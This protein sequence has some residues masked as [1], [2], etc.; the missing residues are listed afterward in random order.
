MQL[1]SSARLLIGALPAGGNT[2]G[3]VN[4]A[5]SPW[6]VNVSSALPAGSNVIGGVTQSG[7]PWTTSDAADGSVSGGSAGTKSILSGGQYN[8]SLPSLTT[9]QQA[10]LQSDS[11]GRLLVGSIASALPAGSNSIGSVTANAGT[12]NFN[13]VQSSG[14][15]L[16][17]N[18]DSLPSIP[19]GSN[20]IGGVTQSGGPW[21]TSDAADGSVTGGSAG[22]KS[23]LSGAQYNASPI[24]L[25]TG[26][27]A[28]LQSDVNG[29][30]LIGALAP[31]ANA[32]GSV[33][34]NSALPAGA[35]SIGSVTANIGTTN[36]LALNSTLLN[37]QGSESGGTAATS[38]QLGGVVYNTSLPSLTNGQQAAMQSDSS[39][40]LLVGSIASNV[41]VGNVSG[42]V[43]LP[44]NAAQETGGNLASINT[45]TTGLNA[46]IQN[47]QGSASGGTAASKSDLA[48][49]VYNGGTLPSL[50]AGQQGGLQLDS[51]GRIIF[52][53]GL[54]TSGTITT[55]C[56]T[57]ST[58]C[59]AGSFVMVPNNGF[60]SAQVQVTG[61]F[62]GATFNVDGTADGV[63]WVTL[64][65]ASGSNGQ[66]TTNS[67]S[68]VGKYRVFRIASLQQIRLRASALGSGSASVAFESGNPTD[69]VEAISL[70]AANN[71]TTSYLDDGSG[72]ALTST[73]VSGHQAL[74]SNVVQSV[75]PQDKSISG[76]LT[77]ACAS[78]TSCGAGSTLTLSV[79]G[80]SSSK[81][82]LSGTW[83]GT[84]VLDCS[85]DSFSTF[86]TLSFAVP[87]GGAPVSSLSS[88]GYWGV[89]DPGSC[90][91]LRARMSAFSSGSAT[92]VLTASEGDGLQH[93]VSLNAAELLGTMNVND[94]SGNPIGSTSLS[95]VNYLDAAVTGTVASGS[96]DANNPVK[97]GGIYES[98][99]TAVST[100]QRSN[101][102]TTSLGD[103]T[104]GDNTKYT[105]ISTATTT[106]VKSGAGLLYAICWNKAVNAA[107]DTIY[108]N[109]AASGTEIGIVT[110]V[111]GGGAGFP[112]GCTRY[113]GM[114][115]NTGLTIVTSAASDLTV[116]YK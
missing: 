4:Q 69:L 17:A 18:I 49:G 20:V 101:A 3:A 40:R 19:S 112:F 39:G 114:Q 1:D 90:N 106:T 87:T 116:L 91:Q 64:L 76:S 97:I 15:N 78:G 8:S 107:T 34:I 71:L 54:S 62:S 75:T 42:T 86:K 79:S 67:F 21:T 45:N 7:G 43:S 102:H 26:Q 29:K 72:N 23:I 48:G 95:S 57:P 58:A 6:G 98:S 5:G 36:G 32:I 66:Y 85:N 104:T 115:F 24:T 60:G 53:A 46:S 9:G 22:S 81:L 2:I 55:T 93:V 56:S 12:G 50:T 63:N 10:A 108:D 84:V 100:G 16:H 61:T 65:T 82:N 83:S 47:T 25:T 35:N 88:N 68:A 99:Q 103:L 92:T 94:G 89:I 73:A 80:I 11:S 110:E 109:T 96:A 105:H 30:L 70:N 14:S 77:A 59:P 33:A 31:G 44:T 38:S 51:A 74:D 111:V 28:S 27:Q 13:V 113:N 52:S 41:N 37:V